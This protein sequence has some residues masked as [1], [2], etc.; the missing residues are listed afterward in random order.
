MA[1]NG[2]QSQPLE[3][4]LHQDGNQACA[5]HAGDSH[6]QEVDQLSPSSSTNPPAVAQPNTC[7]FGAVCLMQKEANA[8]LKVCKICRLC[9]HL[10]CAWELAGSDRNDECG[11][12]AP[13]SRRK[14]VK[15]K[16]ALLRI[17]D[18]PEACSISASDDPNIQAFLDLEFNTVS[19]STQETYA[20]RIMGMIEFFQKDPRYHAALNPGRTNLKLPLPLDLL[21]AFFGWLC[22][23]DGMRTAGSKRKAASAVSADGEEEEENADTPDVAGHERQA[24][25]ANILQV[26]SRDKATVAV[27]TVQG[28][29]SALKYLYRRRNVMFTAIGLKTGGRSLDD[30]LDGYINSYTKEVTRKKGDGVMQAHEGKTTLSMPEGSSESGS[31]WIFSWACC[32]V[33]WN[34]DQ[35][36]SKGFARYCKE[37]FDKLQTSIMAT[38]KKQGVI[39]CAREEYLIS[40]LFWKDQEYQLFIFEPTGG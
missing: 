17:F 21:Q 18:D 34:L 26:S 1:D 29:K 6:D 8:V 30:I 14:R 4:G 33:M 7:V 9:F 13:R 39:R 32:S 5:S 27:S 3:A 19:R 15:D 38:W 23:H 11:K 31:S 24:E 40:L 12:H 22:E 2:G 10:V 36:K 20:Y 25:V 28:Y 16:N 37:G 35:T